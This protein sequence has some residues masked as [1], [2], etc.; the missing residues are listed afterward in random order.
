[1]P[2]QRGNSFH[3]SFG[4]QPVPAVQQKQRAAVGSEGMQT[5]KIA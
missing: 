2:D 5:Q 4:K 3:I 1:M